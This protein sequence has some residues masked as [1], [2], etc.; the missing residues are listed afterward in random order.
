[1]YF[2]EFTKPEL[3]GESRSLEE[4]NREGKNKELIEGTAVFLPRGVRQ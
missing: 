1:M 2:L 3:Q 4:T